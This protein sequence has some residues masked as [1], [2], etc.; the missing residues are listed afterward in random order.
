MKISY[1]TH[2]QT[3]QKLEETIITSDLLNIVFSCADT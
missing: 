2:F 3:S 1:E